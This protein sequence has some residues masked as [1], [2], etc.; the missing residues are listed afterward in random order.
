MV[1]IT[2]EEQKKVKR[3]KR[4]EDGL[5]GLWDNNKHTNIWIIGVPEEGEKIRVWENFW[6]DYS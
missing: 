1:E 5:R 3:I 2:S 6:S 4:M